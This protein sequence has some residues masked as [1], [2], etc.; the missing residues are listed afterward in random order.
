MGSYN[1]ASWLVDRHVARG[2]G[3]R[4][5]VVGR[6]R[7]STYRELLAEVWRAQRAL[8]EL[9]VTAGERVALLLDDDEAFLAWFLGALRSGVVPVPL[10]PVSLAAEVAPPVLDAEATAIVVRNR[11]RA[12]LPAVAAAAPQLRN[13]VVI[14]GA[15][16]GEGTDRLPGGAATHEW[17]W[18]E[19][20]A[21]MPVGATTVDTPGFCLYS[22]GTTG[23]PRAAVHRHGH[24]QATADGYARTVLRISAEDRFLSVAKLHTAYGL[25]NSLTFPFSVGATTILDPTDPAPG[26]FAELVHRSAPTILFVSPHKVVG[27]LESGA[28]ADDLRSVRL[29]VTACEAMPPQVHRRFVERF[30]TPL[31]DGI[32]TTEALHIFLSN[33]VDGVRPGTTGTPVTG[34]ELALLDDRGAEIVVPDT[35]GHLAVRGPSIAT[36]HWSREVTAEVLPKRWLRTGDVYSRSADDYWTFLGRSSDMIKICGMWVS[37]AEVEAVL[38]EHPGVADVAVVGEADRHGLE[39]SVAYVVARRG[40][41]LDTERLEVHCRGHLAPHKVPR[42]IEVV[43]A[44]PTTPAGK[45]HRRALRERRNR[46]PRR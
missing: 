15:P 7:S 18:F 16:T 25:G 29:A 33:T 20:R 14:D 22:S 37:P 31:L 41:H 45:V 28:T 30:A 39:S 43:A 46:C 10:L 42:R 2:G 11:H 27:L 36:E 34:Y 24:L 1:A 17:A 8:A 3:D 44:L 23:T 38:V 6:D 40:V 5:A 35:P 13:V 12:L 21:E 26:G 32:G 9:G 4:I 19:D